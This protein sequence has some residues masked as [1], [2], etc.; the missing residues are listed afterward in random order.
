MMNIFNLFL[1]LLMCTHAVFCSEMQMST[2]D[3]TQQN[4]KTLSTLFKLI[5]KPI[6]AKN[7]KSF[8]EQNLK[9]FNL[10]TENLRD[11][12]YQKQIEPDATDQIQTIDDTIRQI[13]TTIVTEDLIPLRY[14][15]YNILKYIKKNNLY[16]SNPDQTCN[17]I[18]YSP[19]IKIIDSMITTLKDNTVELDD[20]TIEDYQCIMNYIAHFSIQKSHDTELNAQILAAL[21]TIFPND[22][23]NGPDLA[24]LLHEEILNKE[25]LEKRKN[26]L[27]TCLF[28]VS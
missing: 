1:F 6:K 27:E 22:T 7:N 16:H 10:R 2:D 12:L 9:N 15:I 8:Y 3:T 13:R 20:Q 4:Q 18:K 24:K 5:Y 25:A 28:Y 23:C 14:K 19:R 11:A 26:S 21:E 17:K